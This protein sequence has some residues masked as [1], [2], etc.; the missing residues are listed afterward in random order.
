MKKLLVLTLVLGMATMAS[1]TLTIV[2]DAVELMPSDT[3]T[4]SVVAEGGELGSPVW[5]NIEGL[6][7]MDATEADN[8]VQDDLGI[9]DFG[10]FVIDLGSAVG[11]DQTILLDFLIPGTTI[12][13]L[14]QG[15]AADFISFHCEGEGDV[16]ITLLNGD[17]M[18]VLDTL[19]IS[20]I[21]EPMT[22]ALLGL[23]GLFLRRRK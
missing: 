3:N 6:G 2:A 8:L 22:L 4:L 10:I 12:N 19:T 13:I 1:A 20:Q 14:E 18:E 11:Y 5:L 16:L 7:I 21:P 17:T 9:P 23:G 15:T